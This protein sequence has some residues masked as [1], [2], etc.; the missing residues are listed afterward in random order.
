MRNAVL[1]AVLFTEFVLSGFGQSAHNFEYEIKNGS[2]T[3]TGYSGNAKDV[4]VPEKIYG[5]TVAAIGN[6]AFFRKSL[7]SITLPNTITHIGDRAFSYNRLTTLTLPDSLVSIGFLAFSN[8]RLTTLTLPDS[9]LSIGMKAFT[10]NRLKSLTLPNSLDYMGDGAFT[11]NYL[12][13]VSV[14]LTVW[15]FNSRAFDSYVKIT[16]Y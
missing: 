13:S 15:A 2:I 9:L 14:P 5:R 10:E 11:R 12:D 6:R 4:T 3:I 16:W 7:K 1:L 8:N